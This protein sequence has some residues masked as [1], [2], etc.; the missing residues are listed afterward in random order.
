MSCACVCEPGPACSVY[1][2]ICVCVCVPH[3]AALVQ[4]DSKVVDFDQ[5]RLA[6]RPPRDTATTKLRS[7]DNFVGHMSQ[8]VFNKNDFFQMARTGGI[9]NLQTNADFD[10]K[11]TLVNYPI[12][13]LS[14]AAYLTTKLK[15]YSTF[16]IYFSL[17]TT[18]PDG[19][20]MYSRGSKDFLAVELVNG[21]LR[22]V[23]DVGSGP[24]V[25]RSKYRRPLNDNEW[26][27]ITVV[28]PTL[29][30]QIL[31]VDDSAEFDQLPDVSSVH[32]D[33]GDQFYVGGIDKSMYSELPKQVKSREG[34][35]GCVA[36]LDLDGNQ[37]IMAHRANIP[38]DYRDL[39]AEGCEGEL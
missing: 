21:H 36:S 3:S 11:E 29:D 15:L 37:N 19:L 10:K 22:Y 20:I 17:K 12:T 16:T 33:M 34:F 24:R 13:F 2:Y 14:P 31:R 6:K 32:F 4:G 9:Q 30:Q 38:E 18:Q 1:K 5:M 23:Y 39:V 26:H 25:I 35:L 8:F 27:Y 7:K 28:R